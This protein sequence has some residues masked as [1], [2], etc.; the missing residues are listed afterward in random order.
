MMMIWCVAYLTQGVSFFI[1][2]L[3]DFHKIPIAKNPVKPP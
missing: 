2:V 1:L 3:N